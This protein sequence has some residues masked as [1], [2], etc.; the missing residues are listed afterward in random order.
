MAPLPA[1]WPAG[2]RMPNRPLP[3]ELQVRLEADVACIEALQDLWP[4]DAK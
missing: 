1:G 3:S 2:H 4:G